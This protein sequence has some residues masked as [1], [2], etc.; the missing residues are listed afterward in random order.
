ARAAAPALTARL[1]PGER[2][3]QRSAVDVLELAPDRHAV[4]DAAGA[5][6]APHGELAQEMG[7]RLALDRGVRGQDQLTHATL[8]QNCLEL[9]PAELLGADAIERRQVPHQHKVTA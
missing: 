4:G 2:V 9:A 5:D 7:R 6:A 8:F 3:R 1:A